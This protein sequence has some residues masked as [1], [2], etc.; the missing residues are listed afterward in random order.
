M[1]I[2]L[3]YD[4]SVREWID[5]TRTFTREHVLPIEDKFLGD[6]TA[7]GGD[8]LR[9]ELQAAAKDA[10]VF[11]PHAPREFGGGGLSMSNRAP[12]FEEAGYSLFGP[13]ATNIGA[14]DEGNVHLLAH[15]ASTAQKE[16]F[17]APLA[18]GDV[19]SAFAMTE[20][21]PGAGSDPSALTTTATR[22]DGG[23]RIDG[24]KWFI[25][26]ADGAGFFIVM[27]RTSGTPGDRGGA[28]MFLVPADT[29]GITVGRHISTLDR[30]MI[31][32]H[33]EVTFDRVVVP[34]DNVLGAV[35]EGFTYAQ[36]RLG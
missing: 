32:G 23:W 16:Q 36:V 4:P 18:R 3:T 28:T 7:A 1:A 8:D 35:D 17:L 24:H 25:T 30:A 27:A 12:V 19:R 34:E 22:T 29:A 2:D 6:V 21:A 9:R 14:P 31:G 10:A 13:I 20:P 11:A 15:V 33:C 26:G 5:R